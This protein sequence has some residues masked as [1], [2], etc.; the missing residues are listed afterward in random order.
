M[1]RLQI[2]MYKKQLKEE[3]QQEEIEKLNAK[4][5][6]FNIIP[7]KQELIPPPPKV[8]SIDEIKRLVL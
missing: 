2:A 7:H 8:N 3:Q 6:Y 4:T 5:E 1:E